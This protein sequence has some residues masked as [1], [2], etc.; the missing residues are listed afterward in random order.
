MAGNVSRAQSK[1]EQR[2]PLN[3]PNALTVLRLILVP[4]FLVL[5]LQDNSIARWTTLI[6]FCVAAA[7]DHFDGKIARSYGIVTDFGRIADPIADKALTLGAFV[8]LSVTE[9]VPWWFTVVIAVRELGITVM[10]SVFLRRGIVVSANMGGKLKTVLQMFFIFLL[11]IPWDLFLSY[12]VVELLAI[13]FIYPV[14]GAALFMTVW[15]GG[16]YVWEGIALRKKNHS[17]I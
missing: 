16:V 4:I 3:L 2:S 8:I 5:A 12:S 9:F 1:D 11:L 13:Y 10:R 7:T 6:V 17:M 14:G 15:S